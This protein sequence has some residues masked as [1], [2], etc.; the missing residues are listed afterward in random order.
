MVNSFLNGTKSGIEMTAVTN[1]IGLAP[2]PGGLVFSP[3][4][5]QDLAHV[6]LPKFNGGSLHHKGQV[7][8]IFSSERYART[9]INDLQWGVFAALQA[10]DEYVRECFAQY[11][12]MQ[13]TDGQY[14]SMYKP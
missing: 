9:V 13:S 3:C 11:G 10:P 5:T 12:L 8:V 2:A 14:A 7:K 6:M 4:G 1:T